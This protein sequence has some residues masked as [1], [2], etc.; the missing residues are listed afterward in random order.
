MATTW[1]RACRAWSD[2]AA[3]EGGREPLGLRWVRFAGRVVRGFL[4]NRGLVRAASLSY[5]TLL[6]LVP[7]LAL[8]LG[9]ASTVLK[10]RSEEQIEAFVDRLVQAII[11]PA[12]PTNLPPEVQAQLWLSQLHVQWWA[13]GL[14]SGTPAGASGTVDGQV[15]HPG[16]GQLTVPSTAG[17]PAGAEA[18][19]MRDLRRVVALRLQVFIQQTR[20]AELGVLGS[21]GLLAMAILLLARVENT[22]N[23]IWNVP[24]GRSWFMRVVLYWS[25]LTLGPL[26]L[27]GA[28]ALASGPYWE[29]P[30]AWLSQMP[31][32][33]GLVFR[34]LPLLMLWMVFTGFYRLVPN[35][36]VEWSAAMVGG[37]VAAA[38]WH[39]NNLLSVL[40]VS[41]VVTNFKIYGSLGLVPVFMLGL[42]I[43]WAIVLL[44]AQVAY[45][46]QYGGLGGPRILA[47]RLDQRGRELLGLRLMALLGYSFQN[48]QPPRPV[49]ALA[50]EVGAVPTLCLDVLHRLRDAGLVVELSGP[51]TAFVPARPLETITLADV[52]RP[53]RSWDGEGDLGRSEEAPVVWSEYQRMKAAEEQ[54]AAAVTLRE[55][56]LRMG[57]QPQLAGRDVRG[58]RGSSPGASAAFPGA[59]RSESEAR[60]LPRSE[61]PPVEPAPDMGSAGPAHPAP[62]LAGPESDDRG[63]PL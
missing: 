16:S 49:P 38:L 56:V 45:T 20:S 19:A 29:T 60:A 41:R 51:E 17:M 4:R 10:G 25:F 6:S 1:G 62:D 50:A 22:V 35:T 24:R 33:G 39:L 11:P 58:L 46:W 31:L 30:R 12:T 21:I 55:V 47:D 2:R 8:V 3:A 57:A 37:A 61:A 54:V 13:P 14:G 44:G 26:L 18:E 9:V 53:L 5:A 48:S 52:L 27:I 7:L 32:V 34:A 42:Y 63:F 23:D 43:S 40:Y 36:R 28:A 59:G 15:R